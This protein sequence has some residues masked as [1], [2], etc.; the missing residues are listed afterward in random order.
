MS[1]LRLAERPTLG[2]LIARRSRYQRIP[3]ARHGFDGER[4]RRKFARQVAQRQYATVQRIIA[5]D[6]P[7]PA[8]LNQII[9]R[10][11]SRA[12]RCKS[13]KDLRDLWFEL[14]A[15]AGHGDLAT[16]WTDAQR[17]QIKV[18]RFRQID[19]RHAQL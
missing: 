4:F 17:T 12:G 19:P 9:A 6:A 15:V 11:D 5:D 7:V 10:D 8:L 3:N 13:D 2:R 1:T 14:P 16:G 18:R